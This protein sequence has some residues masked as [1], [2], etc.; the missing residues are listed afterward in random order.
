MPE[1]ES[2]EYRFILKVLDK[3][4]NEIHRQQEQIKNNYLQKIFTEE[5]S[6]SQIPE[7][8][9]KQFCLELPS[10][11]VCVVLFHVKEA[12]ESGEISELTAFII[13]N[14]YQDRKS[15][16]AGMPRP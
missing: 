5:I 4:R 1:P 14:V 11:Y 7:P 12:E 16:S 8:V 6:F 9:A 3:N 15:G 13:R 10:P 2:D